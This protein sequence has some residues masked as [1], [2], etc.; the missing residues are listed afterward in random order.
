MAATYRADCYLSPRTLTT[1]VTVLLI[2]LVVGYVLSALASLLQYE[3]LGRMEHGGEWTQEEAS[4]NDLRAGAVA[5][6]VVGTYVVTAIA[7]LKLLGRFN[8]NAWSFGATG[9][10]YTPGWTIV[11]FFVPV[12][13]LF[14]PYQAVQEAWKISRPG[15]YWWESR[16]NSGLVNLWWGLWI[17]SNVLG[18][19]SMRMG[20]AKEIDT[21]R[22]ATLVDLGG[23]VLDV[24][25]SIVAIQLL[26]QLT[27]FQ[28]ERH[29]SGELY[30]AAARTC[31][32]C[33]EPIGDV[34]GEC[35]LCGA[36]LMEATEY[37]AS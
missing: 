12:L 30:G 26:R 22:M 35:P 31:P 27:A 34:L 3:L 15:D 6:L 21:L 8:H 32:N 7:F 4:L 9:M 1:V 11:W 17:S 28:E 25:L 5:I 36:E 37:A 29:E 16:P 2:V 33:G 14:R 20:A 23:S 13:N 10:R 18:Q 24:V 19:I